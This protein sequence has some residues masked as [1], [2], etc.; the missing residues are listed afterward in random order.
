[1]NAPP[2]RARTGAPVPTTSVITRVDAR[3][4]SMEPIVSTQ[5]SVRFIQH[6]VLERG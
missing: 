1:M 5:A 3:Q 6:I 4:D 2:I